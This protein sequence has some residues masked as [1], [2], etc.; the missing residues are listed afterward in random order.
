MVQNIRDVFFQQPIIEQPI[1][2]QICTVSKNIISTIY[3]FYPKIG[4]NFLHKLH[5]TISISI[6]HCRIC[7]LIDNHLAQGCQSYRIESVVIQIYH[8]R[9]LFLFLKKV[10]FNLLVLLWGY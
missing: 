3:D 8:T 10:V 6:V 5:P 7:F 9:N 1:S 2:L 4:L